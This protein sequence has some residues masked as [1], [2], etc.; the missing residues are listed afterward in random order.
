MIM[1]MKYLLFLLAAVLLLSLCATAQQATGTVKGVLA[2][3]S[4]AVI[5]A[6]NV[7][8]VGN[9]ATKTAQSQSD[10]SY[11]FTGVA[12]GQYNVT[13]TFPGFAPFTKAVTVSAG[14]TIQVP[15]QLAVRAEKQEV[16][17]ADQAG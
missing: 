7:S 5:P 13:I 11:T 15:I 12:P 9:G 14:G 1:R 3:D 10:G 2:D 6:A 17:V 16:T 8:L 4:G